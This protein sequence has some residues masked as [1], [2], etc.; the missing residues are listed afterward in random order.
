MDN[1]RISINRR[2]FL[3]GAT[4]IAGAAML[5]LDS[6]SAW[7]DTSATPASLAYWDAGFVNPVGATPERAFANASANVHITGH[8]VPRGQSH[9]ISAINAYYAYMLDGQL[10]DAPFY[11]WDTTMLVTGTTFKMPTTQRNGILLTMELTSQP[12]T[13]LSFPFT[14]DPA[15]SWPKLRSGTYALAVGSPNWPAYSLLN[16]AIVKPSGTGTALADFEYIL[17]KITA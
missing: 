15:Q 6:A 10:V 3:R 7:A 2:D 8:H 14:V 9:Q 13:P 5:G 1:N 12:G 11:A 4:V 16:G 17:I